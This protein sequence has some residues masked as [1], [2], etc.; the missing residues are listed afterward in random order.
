MYPALIQLRKVTVTL[1]GPENCALQ[2][3]LQGQ[4]GQPI[5]IAAG[6]AWPLASPTPASHQ[7]GGVPPPP[8]S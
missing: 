5:E 7:E 2:S 4:A 8:L 3:K 1:V 6:V